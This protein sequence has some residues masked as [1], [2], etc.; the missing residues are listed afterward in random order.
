MVRQCLARQ[1]L[2]RLYVG[3][4]DT[5]NPNYFALL[6]LYAKTTGSWRNKKKKMANS[7]QKIAVTGCTHQWL[8]VNSGTVLLGSASEF[9]D[10]P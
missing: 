7:K 1:L 9:R 6:L 3:H 2:R 8:M 5:I 4:F 10:R